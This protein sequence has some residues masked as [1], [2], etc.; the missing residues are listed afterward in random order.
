MIHIEWET[1]KIKQ[2]NTHPPLGPKKFSLN[3]RGLVH[4][5]SL[6]YPSLKQ[7]QKSLTKQKSFTYFLLTK[8]SSTHKKRK[9]RSKKKK[10]NRS[11]ATPIPHLAGQA[12]LECTT[13]SVRERGSTDRKKRFPSGFWFCWELNQV[14][15]Y[16][17][18]KIH[19]CRQR[20]FGTQFLKN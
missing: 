8:L 1:N 17:I 15:K 11:A 6:G 12:K 7:K 9:R 20:K 16:T 14:T 18:S 5:K 3:Q 13:S 4:T 19:L 10:S 2:S